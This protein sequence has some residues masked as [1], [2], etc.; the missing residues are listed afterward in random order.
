MSEQISSCNLSMTKLQ[1]HYCN[2]CYLWYFNDFK[3]KII[4]M[5][6]NPHIMHYSPGF[7]TSAYGYNLRESSGKIGKIRECS[8]YFRN[9][10]N[11]FLGP[12]NISKDTKH[13]GFRLRKNSGKVGSVRIIS[14]IVAIDSLY[15][16]MLRESLGK[17]GRVRIVLGIFVIDSLHPKI[18]GKTANTVFLAFGRVRVKSRKFGKSRECSDHFRNSCNR[19]LGPENIRKGTKHG[20]F[21]LR[22]SSGKIGRAWV[23]SGI[24]AIDSSHPKIYEKTPNTAFLA[25]GRV[26]TLSASLWSVVYCRIEV[27]CRKRLFAIFHFCRL[28]DGNRGFLTAPKFIVGP[29]RSWG[30]ANLTHNARTKFAA[31]ILRFDC[32]KIPLTP[33]QD[34]FILMT[35]FRSGI[36]NPNG[37]WSYSIQSI[38][39][40]LSNKM[41]KIIFAKA[42]L[43][44]G[45]LF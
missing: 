42:N 17:I 27:M 1:Q 37:S 26:C 44:A 15:L 18:Y 2:G 10:R 45:H 29:F 8:H 41:R 11:L 19:F 38:D 6:E 7:Y 4:A 39:W 20:G 40:S 16:E 32:L 3:N 24:V 34:T 21:R 12:E 9:S 31:A 22:E 13:S 30:Y 33:E 43:Q 14:G 28:R 23:V 36:W 25:F 35:H 5:R